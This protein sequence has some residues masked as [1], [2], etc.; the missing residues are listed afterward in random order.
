MSSSGVSG[1]G[2]GR[3]VSSASRREPGGYAAA[4][5]R[6]SSKAQD[7]ATQRA[8]IDRAASARG[9]T[10]T[11]WFAEKLSGKTL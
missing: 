11:E 7:H 3:A 1:G 8:A 5:V 9:D 2:S 10:I 4:Y 6:V